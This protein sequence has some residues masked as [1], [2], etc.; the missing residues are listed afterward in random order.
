MKKYPNIILVGI[1]GS[2]KWTQSKKII[3]SFWYKLFDTGAELRKISKTNSPLWNSIKKIME[4]WWYVPSEYIRDTIEN[5]IEK[6][7]NFSILFDSP[8]RSDEQ[9]KVIRPILG[10]CIVICLELDKNIAIERLLHRRIDPETGEIFNEKIVGNINPNN[11]NKLITRKDD[12]IDAITKRI[13]WSINESLPLVKSWEKQWYKVYYIDAD[14]DID[15]VFDDISKII[16][17]F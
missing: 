16:Y 7:K 15:I 8:V 12:N 6:N 3:E 11:W 1:Q 17:S 10:D 4:E 14:R 5:F 9:D 2:W 13:E